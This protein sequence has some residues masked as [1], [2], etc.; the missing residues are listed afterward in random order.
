M[1]MRLML[2]FALAVLALA[3]TAMA[4][5][6]G[7]A[8]VT[9]E[10]AGLR[11]APRESSKPHT[12]L[13]QGE[14][15]EVRGEKLEFVQVYDYRRE[16]GGWV[17]SRLVQRFRLDAAEAPELLAV[18][19][20]LR[21][22]PGREALGIGF[23]AA[24]IQAAPKEVLNG[25]QGVE[26]LDALGTF[27]ERLARRASAGT[28][29][30]AEQAEVSAHL[31][32]ALRHGVRFTSREAEG[33]VLLCY[34]GDA[35]QRV[36]AMAATAE[37][38][39]RAALAVTRSDCI[40]PGLRPAERRAFDTWRSEMLDRVNAGELP[41]A[42]KN[43]VHMRRAAVWSTLAYHQARRGEPATDAA[44]RALSEL[45]SVRKEDLTEGD[46]R[47]YSDAV[48]R[49][50]ASRWAT[51]PAKPAPK[52]PDSRPRLVAVSGNAGETCLLL[53]DAK[54]DL[55]APLARRC[56][57]GLPWLESATLNRE[58]NAIAIAVQQTD[59]WREAWVFRKTGAGWTVRVLPPAT[60]TPG[61]GY[62]EV[63]GWVPGGSQMLVARE[64]AGDGR[65]QRAFELVRLDTL[66]TVRTAEEPS[67]LSVFQRW[68]D[69]AWK[70]NTVSLR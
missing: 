33:R 31:D 6:L 25:P 55:L 28:L 35:F 58:S 15:L 37:Q 38:R 32:V 2:V 4:G 61:V 42:M 53:V 18:I 24:Y 10:P 7:I 69:P 17:A 67:H 13:S 50:G 26:A 1:N 47:A 20:F 36:L 62:A 57:Y 60:F 49:V 16:R 46:A 54:N 34:D 39:A 52:Q 19:R 66:A 43:R 63:A 23:A 68:Q 40:D 22:M 5:D 59:T 27:A 70:Q 56:T 65:Y 48:M 44:Q 9:Q 21:E 64:A 41:P 11:A 45:G 8:I 12:L 29:G 30:K 3:A 51:V 14:A